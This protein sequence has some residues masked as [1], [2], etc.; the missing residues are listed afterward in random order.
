ML[1]MV[2]DFGLYS[3]HNGKPLKS[4]NRKAFFKVHIGSYVN[5]T[6]QQAIVIVQVTN[7]YDR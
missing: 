5:N 6:F 2:K 3:K 1:T 7:N 4:F